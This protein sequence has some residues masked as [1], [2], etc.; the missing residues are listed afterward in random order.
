MQDVSG[1]EQKESDNEMRLR[2]E[3]FISIKQPKSG[4]VVLIGT[5]LEDS[6]GTKV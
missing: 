2:A 6:L 5:D 4:D 1:L 3:V